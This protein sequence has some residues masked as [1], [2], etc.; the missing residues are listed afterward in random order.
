MLLDFTKMHF[1]LDRGILQFGDSFEF[2]LPYN[3]EEQIKWVF[4][5]N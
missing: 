5:D 4:D 1:V 3:T 2:K